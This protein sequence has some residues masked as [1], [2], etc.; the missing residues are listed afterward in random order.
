[1]GSLRELQRALDWLRSQPHKHK[2]IIGGN[3]DLLLDPA[4]QPRDK[5]DEASF[6]S[7]HCSRLTYLNGES[8]TIEV[9]GRKLKVYGSPWTP[10]QGNWAFQYPRDL[11]VWHNRVPEDVDI[12]ITHGPPKYHLDLCGLG[13]AHLLSEL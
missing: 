5:S 1:L 9:S 2:L 10:Q 6:E 4:V 11:N 12:L 13:C 8:I 3:H 7:L